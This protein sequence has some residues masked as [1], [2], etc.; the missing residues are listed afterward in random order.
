MF[1]PLGLLNPFVMLVKILFQNIWKLG[2]QWDAVLPDDISSQFRQWLQGLEMLKTW[3]L[4]RSYFVGCKWKELEGLEIHIFCDAS[5]KGYGACVYLR[6]PIDASNCTAYRVALVMSRA[7]VAPIKRVT[8]PCLELLGALMGARLLGFV[9]QALRLNGKVQCRLW[10]DSTIALSW[11][12]GDPQRWK[13]F[14]SNRVTE[15]QDLSE[16]S[17]WFHVS[18]ENNPADLLTR[19]VSAEKLI[20]SRIWLSGP[21]W[22]STHNLDYLSSLCDFVDKENVVS[23]DRSQFASEED[24]L[25]TVSL[26]PSHPFPVERWGTIGKAIRIVAWVL[27]FIENLRKPPIERNVDCISHQEFETANLK[28]LSC[29]PNMVLIFF[30]S[31]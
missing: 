7:R 16:P 17:H 2:L 25:V 11:I 30:M 20:S 28:L 15:I 8:L 21:D 26:D 18:S 24:V 29:V 12:K 27:R 9:L 4:A 5:E 10:T 6:N 3:R 14:V 1:D 23:H 19:G 13:A 31:F 22:L